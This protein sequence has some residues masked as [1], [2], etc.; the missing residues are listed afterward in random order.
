[1][2]LKKYKVISDK[3]WDG[4]QL[5][6]KGE[7]VEVETDNVFVAWDSR[8][9]QPVGDSP[10]FE[11]KTDKETQEVSKVVS[12]KKPK[13]GKA[14]ELPK[15]PLTPHTIPPAAKPPATPPK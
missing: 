14:P 2:A 12:S 1:M 10:V 3:Y 4:V 9:L 11:T 6:D 8:V 15:A 5:H 13:A 7:T